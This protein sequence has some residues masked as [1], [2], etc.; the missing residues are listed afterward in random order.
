MNKIY[1]FD[2]IVSLLPFAPVQGKPAAR[3]RAASL[4]D[5]DAIVI[6]DNE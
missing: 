6:S 1:G 4:D 3:A 5:A 2:N